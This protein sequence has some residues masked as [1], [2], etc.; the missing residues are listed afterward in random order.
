MSLLNDASLVLIPSGYKEDKVYSIIPSDGSGDLDFVRGSDGTRINSLGQVE[1]VCWNKLQY[2]EDLTNGVWSKINTTA[3]SNSTTAPNGTIT[4]DTLTATNTNYLNAYQGSMPL[5]GQYTFSVY[6]KNNGTNLIELYLFEVGVGFAA[7]GEINFSAETFTA[8]IGSGS[9]ENVGNGWYRC[10]LSNNLNN[11]DF[12]IGYFTTST[13][14]TRSVYTWGA[15]LNVGSTA[16]PYFPTTDRLNVP[17]LTYENGCPSLLLEKQS[18]NVCLYS[19][20]FNNGNWIGTNSGTGSAPVVTANYAISP[21]GTQNADLVVFNRGAGNSSSDF[22]WLYQNI[23]AA[24]SVYSM[25]CYVKAATPADIGK[26]L[27]WRNFGGGSAWSVTLTDEWQRITTQATGAGTTQEIGFYNRGG[28]STGNSVSV[29]MWGFQAEASAYPTSY[30]K[31]TSTSVTRL[32]DS[33]YKTGIS[34]L[35]GQTSGTMFWHSKQIGGAQISLNSSASVSSDGIQIYTTSTSINVY[36]QQGGGLVL[37]SSIG[38]VTEDTNFKVALAYG[39]NF[40]KVYINGVET[41]TTTTSI[42]IPTM[43]MLN[44]TYYGGGNAVSKSETKQLILFKSILTDTELEQLT[45]I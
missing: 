20:E 43:T 7:R 8:S 42:T 27:S 21:D 28:Y 35:I 36:I 2:S 37:I 14:G 16:K 23:S 29:L 11:G 19:E 40:V 39:A 31:T 25:S 10:S 22:S 9:I 26:N 4:A 15:Q 44:L 32:A 24:V 30:I 6:L 45:T 33:C 1:N 38:N 13:I 17:R 34:S 41:Y 18:T 12:T 3:S 5:S